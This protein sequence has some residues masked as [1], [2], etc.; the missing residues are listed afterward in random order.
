ME[1]MSS[2]LVNGS[3]AYDVLLGY[4]GNFTDGMRTESLDQLSLSFFCPTAIRHFGGTAS[5]IAWHS[6]KLGGNARI[7]GALG[8][9]GNDYS[10]RLKHAGV[11]TSLIQTDHNAVTAT[12]T[13]GTDTTGHQLAFFT[14]G[15]D[16]TVDW[17][18]IENPESISYALS[19][20]RDMTMMLQ[21]VTW[22]KENNI[23]MLF[24]PGQQTVSLNKEDLIFAIEHSTG[25]IC[26]QHE[27]NMIADKTGLTIDDVLKNCLYIIVTK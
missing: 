13:I 9:D 2:I 19:G 23:A 26:N 14:P 17:A 20:A 7:V 4:E 25:L 18:E 12:A 11:D 22:A 16:S 6:A 24:D 5:N 15:A 3:I 10:N 21:A 27:W 1:H 8:I